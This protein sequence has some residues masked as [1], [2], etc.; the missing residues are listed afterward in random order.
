MHTVGTEGTRAPVP[1]PLPRRRRSCSRGPFRWASLY[2]RQDIV[3][4]PATGN[5][6]LISRTRSA[7]RDSPKEARPDERR[8]QKKTRQEKP[9]EQG[10]G[11]GTAQRRRRD[12]GEVSEGRHARPIMDYVSLP[13]SP[14]SRINN[15]LPVLNMSMDR[16]A[17]ASTA[18]STG[19]LNEPIEPMPP[20]RFA[21]LAG[22]ALLERRAFNAER[23]F[24]G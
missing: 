2:S 16:V 20:S 7:T 22:F 4:A 10:Q 12:R 18:T 8:Q 19:S 9:V 15:P 6:R 24:A 23:A 21:R 5:R 17:S 11:D 1:S 3:G 14:S 13:I